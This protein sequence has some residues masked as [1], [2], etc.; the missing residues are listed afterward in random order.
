MINEFIEFSPHYIC[1]LKDK[2]KKISVHVIFII[3]M[4]VYIFVL[5]IAFLT[6][7]IGHVLSNKNKI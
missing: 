1:L 6:K 2:I 3:K 7:N 5:Y 4:L